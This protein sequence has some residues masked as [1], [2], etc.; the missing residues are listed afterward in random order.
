MTTF[1]DTELDSPSVS[2]KQ[3]DRERLAKAMADYEARQKVQTHP[4][5]A[6]DFSWPL[7]RHR[8]SHHIDKLRGAK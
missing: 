5:E 1:H 4:V 7:R 6:V 2:S 3:K 8:F